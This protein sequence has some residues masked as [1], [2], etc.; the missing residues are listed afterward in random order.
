MSGARVVLY[1]CHHGD[2]HSEILCSTCATRRRYGPA[3][4]TPWGE[5]EWLASLG[6]DLDGALTARASKC[7]T[8][9]A[10]PAW[11]SKGAV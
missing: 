10:D 5:G 3:T 7:Q 4:R 11:P 9:G 8:C 6:P 2:G 1:E